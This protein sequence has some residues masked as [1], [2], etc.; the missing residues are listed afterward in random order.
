MIL[1]QLNEADM[2]KAETK[3]TGL[4]QIAHD[5]HQ[6]SRDNKNEASIRIL[7]CPS[8]LSPVARQEWDRI[9]P[10]LTA[11]GILSS[12]DRTQLAIYCAAYAR[13]VE[14][15]EMLQWH[16]AMMKSPNGHPMQSPYLHTAHKEQEIILRIASEFGFTPASRSR[17]FSYETKQSMLLNVVEGPDVW[18]IGVK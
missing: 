9:V 6:S 1:L 14:A 2:E 18:S 3:Q 8:H 4:K 5:Q 10:E 16:G 15:E 11:I 7:E 12:A 13:W 17:I